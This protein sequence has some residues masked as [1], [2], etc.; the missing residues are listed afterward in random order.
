MSSHSSNY[1]DSI[2]VVGMHIRVP[3]A[4]SLNQYWTNLRDGIESIT[5]FSDDELRKAGVDEQ[6]LKNPDYVKA[7]GKLDGIEDFDASF[8]DMTPKEAEILD[9]QHRL[10]MEGV[11]KALEHAGI[12][13]ERY[14][15]RIGLYAGVGFNGYL[16]HHIL[17]NPDL[18]ES[19]GA[20]Q[21]SLNND[22]DFATTR[23]AY[24]FNLQ[25][26]AISINTACS[27]SLVA[28][29]LA[30]QSL[31]NHQC[32]TAI[33]GGCSIHLPQDQ[34]YHYM[35]GGTLSPDGHCRPFDAKAAGTIDG[36]GTASIVLK[37]YE[38]AI[39]DRDTIYAVIRGFA[40]NN[41]GSVKVGYTAPSVEGQADVIMEALEMADTTPDQIDFIETHGTGTDLGDSVEIAALAEAFGQSKNTTALGS[42]K[43]NIGHLDT[44]AGVAGLI[45]VV[46]SMQNEIIP[47]TCH[48]QTPNPTLRLDKTPFFVN[49][50]S[51]EWTSR[52]NKPRLAGIS[53]FGIGGTNA[54]VVI[55]QSPKIQKSNDESEWLILPFSAKSVRALLDYMDQVAGHIESNRDQSLAD[56]AYTLQTG[57]RQFEYRVALLLKANN[58][59]SIAK[60]IRE[61]ASLIN[62]E[63]SVLK[64]TDISVKSSN[65]SLKSVS[66]E[67]NSHKN[68]SPNTLPSATD[69]REILQ[70]IT[71]KSIDEATESG[72][73]SELCLSAQTWLNG[74]LPDW[75]SISPNRYH[76]AIPGHPLYKQRYWI[77]P[78]NGLFQNQ[79]ALSV[80]MQQVTKEPSIDSWF[81]LPGWRKTILRQSHIKSGSK[82]L[83]IGDTVGLSDSLSEILTS[84]GA[85][86]KFIYDKQLH[87]EKGPTIDTTSV[88][89]WEKYFKDQKDFKPE[90]I[91]HV[92]LFQIHSDRDKML[93]YAFDGMVALGQA[94]GHTYFSDEIDLVL[95]A[96]GI[97]AFEQPNEINPAKCTA[98]G[99]LRVIA[100]EYPNISTRVIDIDKNVRPPA[101]VAELTSEEHSANIVLRGANRWSE[102]F[103]PVKITDNQTN[104][105]IKENGL[106]LITG[107]L[108]DIGLTLA[109]YMATRHPVKLALLSRSKFPD[110]TDWTKLLKEA[111]TSDR[112]KRQIQQIEHIE[113]LGSKV[114][115]FSADV[116]DEVTMRQLIDDL[117]QEHHR[118]D[119]II[120]AAGI[121]GQKS[122]VTLND[123][124]T[125]EGKQN[126]LDQ[127][128]SKVEGSEVLGRIMAKKSFD[129]CLICSSLSPILGGLGF[130]AYAAT[131][132]YADA[133]VENLNYAQPGKWISVNWE[134]WMFDHD[135]VPGDS[136]NSSALE[137]GMS[138]NDG[139]EIF[140]RII[141][142]NDLDRIVI[143]SG[144]LQRRISQWVEKHSNETVA[145]DKPSHDR[146]MHIGSYTAP[147]SDTEKQ[148]VQLWGKLLGMNGIG[149]HDSFFELGGNSLLLTQL[150]AMIR[151]SF[152]AELSLSAMFEQPT[153]SEIAR[154]IEMVKPGSN[155]NGD[156]RDV[157]II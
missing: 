132:L 5:F 125:P 134:G 80:S 28:T 107:G 138:P 46:L 76:V 51:T 61:S 62:N 139:V 16:V 42:V 114:H 142:R 120:H 31:L 113:S 101:L 66:S 118:I 131:N 90:H 124:R 119:G 48:Y 129:F 7:S 89:D 116:S 135:V 108:G 68:N 50:K 58:Y 149:I 3:G 18:L 32:D 147:E 145:S 79:D 24:K 53:S 69:A 140:S 36:N 63:I 17:T 115:I 34:G 157:G 6:T 30:A 71:E 37:R 111:S 98:V 77:E 151:K 91:I 60:I 102:F 75:D 78:K 100:Q 128:P 146:P 1:E 94:L 93:S 133:L 13:P 25:G 136:A 110:R 8:F 126:N 21:L 123:A 103:E 2:A 4:D 15:G 144:N 99:P 41:D 88:E 130:A 117:E 44:A 95:V 26:P 55:E 45:K 148:L 70:R 84:S 121:V 40:V 19:A 47:P 156:D 154:N 52:A 92:G 150:V 67:A 141:C 20:W 12:D 65:T 56:I 105:R 82:W 106:Y 29:C 57:R 137:L 23:I 153:I 22:K 64:N 112:L 86:V 10:L 59:K 81:Y 83:I 33:A 39:K 143:S 109:R 38:D 74:N 54:H 72:A 104:T 87:P 96:D 43:S 73:K 49:N 127:F 14:S 97:M 35:T 9:P 122:F 152:Q 27:T 85:E 155:N 11:W